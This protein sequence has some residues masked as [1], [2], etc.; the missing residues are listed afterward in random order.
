VLL[1]QTFVGN[2]SAVCAASTTIKQ[3]GFGTLPAA[4]CGSTA[5]K[6]GFRY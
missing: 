3:Y 5:T 6:Q 4:L 1:Q 2:T